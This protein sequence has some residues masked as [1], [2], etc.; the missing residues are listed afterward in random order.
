MKLERSESTESLRKLIDSPE[1]LFRFDC[2]L[3]MPSSSISMDDRESIVRCIAMHHVIYSQKA[4][5]DQIREGFQVQANH[6]PFAHEFKLFWAI[7]LFSLIS[8]S[9]ILKPLFVEA[10]RVKLTCS[11]VLEL[12]FINWSEEGCNKRQA[13]EELVLNLTY[14]LTELQ[15]RSRCGVL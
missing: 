3:C 11:S 15:G 8:C 1:F 6:Q 12:F 7:R 5:L 10:G 14:Y 2:G 4:E 9:R 13:Q